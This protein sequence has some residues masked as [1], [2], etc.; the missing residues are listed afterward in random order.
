MDV[1]GCMN[2]CECFVVVCAAVT[3]QLGKRES[4]VGQQSSS[5]QK[6][7]AHRVILIAHLGVLDVCMDSNW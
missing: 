5:Y 2:V 1:C 4:D 6:A 3:T 7:I